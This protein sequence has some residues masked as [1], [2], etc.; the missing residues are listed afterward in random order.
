MPK[1]IQ[2]ESLQFQR[3]FQL[4]LVKNQ[5]RSRHGSLPVCPWLA[6]PAQ[7][8]PSGEGHRSRLILAQPGCEP[9][10]GVLSRLS[11][12]LLQACLDYLY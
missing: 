7:E 10:D 12:L 2:A 4:R 8:V 3:V 11:E 1:I 9:C 5:M 6:S